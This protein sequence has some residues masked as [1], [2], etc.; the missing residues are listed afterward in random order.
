MTYADLVKNT[1]V[2]QTALEEN[3]KLFKEAT[4][5]KALLE[6]DELARIH[7]SLQKGSADFDG[8]ELFDIT[9]LDAKE[10]KDIILKKVNGICDDARKTLEH[11]TGFKGEPDKPAVKA[12]KADIPAD[13]AEKETP[14]ALPEP[15]GQ[16]SAQ[17]ESGLSENEGKKKRG[18][19]AEQKISDRE[20]EK[21]YFVD[22]KNAREIERECGESYW[23]LRRRLQEMQEQKKKTAKECASSKGEQAV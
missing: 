5:I 23:S 1:E 7:I 2:L 13:D 11:L 3:L 18:R 8:D 19:Y 6:D 4:A 9:I 22:C 10:M 15:A 16:A 20:L 12:E 17:T 21:A 14:V